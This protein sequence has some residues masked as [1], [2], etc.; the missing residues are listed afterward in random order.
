MIYEGKLYGK[1]AGKYIP[2]EM[3]ASEIEALKEENRRLKDFLGWEFS[4]GGETQYAWRDINGK[5]HNIFI[6]ESQT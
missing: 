5:Q 6:I 1:V 3:T 4:E 2:L